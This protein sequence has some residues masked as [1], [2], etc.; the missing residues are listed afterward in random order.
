MYTLEDLDINVGQIV[1]WHGCDARIEDVDEDGQM[2]TVDVMG[3]IIAVDPDEFAEQN[4]DCVIDNELDD[5]EN[6]YEYGGCLC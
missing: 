5:D 4:P 3:E 1:G 6:D 2:I